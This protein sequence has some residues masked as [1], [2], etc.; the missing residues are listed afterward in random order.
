MMNQKFRIKNLCK[1]EAEIPKMQFQQI[2][3]FSIKLRL[4]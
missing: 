1:Q 3:T 2:P 4:Q